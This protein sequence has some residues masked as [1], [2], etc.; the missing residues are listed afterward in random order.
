METKSENFSK[1]KSWI[2]VQNL[3]PIGAGKFPSVEKL[4]RFLNPKLEKSTKST[5]V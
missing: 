2:L 4:G 5:K 3:S 1:T